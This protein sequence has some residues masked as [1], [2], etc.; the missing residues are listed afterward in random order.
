MTNCHRG[1]G[2]TREDKDLDPHVE[3]ARGIHRGLD[4]D[5]ESTSSSDTTIVCGGSETDGPIND[6]LPINQAKLA[7]LTKEIHNLCQQM[8][9]EEGQPTKRF[10]CIE[11]ELQNLSLKLQAQSTS[12]PA[13]TEP[14]GEVIHQYRETL[15]TTQKQTNLINSLLQ[16]ITV[17]NEHNSTKLEE[18]LTDL[19]TAE[20]L[21]NESRAKLAKAKSRGLTHT[22]VTDPINAERIWDEIKDL[23]RLKLCNAKIHTYTLHFIVIQKHEKKS[24]AAYVHL[25]KTE[26]KQCN[27]TNDAATIRIVVKGLRNLQTLKDAIT[28]VEKSLQLNNLPQQSF[29]PQQST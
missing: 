9:A 5:N 19:E 12:I 7:A 3:D 22:L 24:L 15:C 8:K 16:D 29:H 2:C 11:Q 4:N 23:L 28:E 14:F 20:D 25:F 13:P 1:T 18:W 10:D 26:A 21:T 6:L 27:C 17:F